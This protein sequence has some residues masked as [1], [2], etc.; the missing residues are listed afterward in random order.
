MMPDP[1]MLGRSVVVGPGEG[2]PGPWSSC[3][4]VRVTAVDRETADELGAAWR[5][6]RSVVI[7]LGPGLGLDDPEVPPAVAVTGRE[8]WEWSVDLDLVG[9]RLHHAIW[10]NAVDGRGGGNEGRWRWADLACR[11]GAVAADGDGGGDVVLPDGRPA[12][13]DGGPVD[14]ALA[15]L[16]AVAVLHRI[17]L[18]HGRLEP[19][20]PNDPVGVALAGDQ[21]AAVAASGAGARIIA[22]AGSGKTRVLTERARLL[23]QRWRLP[24]EAMALV[25]YNVRA[26]NEMRERLGQVG[27]VRIRTLNALGLRLC[28]RSSTIE[29]MEVRRILGDL[30]TFPKRAETDPVAPW[31]EALGRVRLG[32]VD[33]ATVEGEMPDVSDL[34]RVARTYRARLA[35][36]GVVDFDEQVT[37]AIE[38]LLADPDYRAKMQRFARILLVDEFQ[39]LTPAHLLLIRL[40]TGPAGAVFAVGDD[41]Q[42]IYGYAGASPRWLVDF[43]TWFPGAGLHSLEVNYRCPEA[44]V[45]G[46]SNLLTRNALRVTKVIRAAAAAVV[47]SD[48]RTAH[49]GGLSVLAGDDGPARRSADRVVDL[50]AGGADPGEVAVLARVNA[51]LAPVQV[52]LRTRE[53]P[54]DGGVSQRFLQRGGV[55]AALAWLT[56]AT[57]PDQSLPGTVLREVARRPKRGMSASLLD[58]LSRKVST[59]DLA[60]LADWLGDKGSDREAGKVRDLS[61]DLRRVRRAAQGGTT[62][63]VLAVLRSQIGDG[64]LDASATAIDQ[65]SH[66]AGSA[67]GD[68]LDALME[69]A[70][71]EDDPGRFPG[72]LA[73][74][75]SIP[76][77]AGGVTLASIHAVKGREWPHVVV[78]HAT[79]GLLPHRLSED[80]EEERRIFHVALTRCRISAAIVPGS[81]PSP[82]IGELDAPGIPEPRPAAPVAATSRARENRPKPVT[83]RSAVT[84]SE[85][86]LGATGSRFTYQGHDHEVIETSGVGVRSRVGGGPATMVIGFGTTVNVSDRP[87]VLVHPRFAEAWE[88]L[89]AW[90]SERAG[91]KP[92]FVVFDDKTLWLVAALLPTQEAELLAISGIGPVKL[93]NYGDELIAMAES[94]RS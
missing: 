60:G 59:D 33:P 6:R 32:L 57:A 28:G 39:D 1:M 69:L 46:A 5:E 88:Q 12:L 9:E 74:Q 91:G 47:D 86:L 79:D 78:H 43:R 34:E 70:E 7:E 38:R 26:A 90:R 15:G 19:L 58:L 82:F 30:L 85:V 83:S 76:D 17:S 10:A 50:I 63:H 52:L 41:D 40:L 23:L 75:L 87:V 37:G 65:W 22:P 55:R 77:D 27:E 45:T 3:A 84:A 24:P 18:E 16:G 49:G 80:V 36:L 13:C 64:G 89:R 44:V 11:L 2:A 66:G 51:S 54:V 73:E 14:A 62:A 68:D 72:W 71:L 53:V 31:I 8:P 92:A 35:E 48:G 94:L 93:E 29:E 81:P 21:L 67:H 4:R 25:T 56:V 20:G 42:T 61:D